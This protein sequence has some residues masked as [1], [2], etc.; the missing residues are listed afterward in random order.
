VLHP[1]FVLLHIFTKL[2]EEVLVYWSLNRSEKCVFFYFL[3]F[4]EL[5][6]LEAII[7]DLQE[8]EW[9]WRHGLD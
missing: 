3:A 1:V 8:V 5:L 6:V 2:T 4:R 7:P 9:W